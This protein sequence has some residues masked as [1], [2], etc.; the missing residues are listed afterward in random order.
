MMHRWSLAKKESLH[1]GWK[2]PSAVGACSTTPGSTV[3][4]TRETCQDKQGKVSMNGGAS[5]RP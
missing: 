2:P 4:A 3:S 1:R 5:G